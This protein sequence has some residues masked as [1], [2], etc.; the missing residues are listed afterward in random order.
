MTSRSQQRLSTAEMVAKDREGRSYRVCISACHIPL[1]ENCTEA[2]KLLHPNEAEYFRSLQYERRQR[3]Y[4]L[5]RYS[6]KRAAAVLIGEDQLDKI[7]IDRGIFTQPV[8]VHANHSNIQVS[9]SHCDNVG[10]SIGF[11]EAMPMG[12]DIERIDN[13]KIETLEAQMTALEQGAIRWLPYPAPVKLLLLWT[14]KEALSK[15]LKTGLMIHFKFLE[16]DHFEIMDGFIYSCF[17]GFPQYCTLSYI[18]EDYVCSIT[19]P[20]RASFSIE[21]LHGLRQNLIKVISDT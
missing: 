3:S 5:G 1:I 4:L 6:A 12:I 10:I 11:P 18:I 15:I 19:Y 9:I 16:I 7:M 2:V 13:R 20:K 14:A 17:E 8:V 21:T